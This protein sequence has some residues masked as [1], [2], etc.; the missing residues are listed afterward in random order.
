[1][2]T[3]NFQE[4]SNCTVNG[5][6]YDGQVKEQNCLLERIRER[7]T[8]YFWRDLDLDSKVGYTS[9]VLYR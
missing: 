5:Q 9:I 3:P 7:N 2:F 4:V 6:R 8:Y 1:M